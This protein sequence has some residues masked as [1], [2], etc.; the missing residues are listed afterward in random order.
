[1]NKL[2]SLSSA[3]KFSIVDSYVEKVEKINKEKENSSSNKSSE[4]QVISDG[5]SSAVLVE[6]S[7]E[8]K[9]SEESWNSFD[10]L[11]AIKKGSFK[12]S[13]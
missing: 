6:K 13:T 2:I 10:V 11:S 7:E 5:S 3:G 8:K 12:K 4:L 9:K 1:M